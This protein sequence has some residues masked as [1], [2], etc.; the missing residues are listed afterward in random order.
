LV[1]SFYRQSY[2]SR[3]TGPFEIN[4][5]TDSTYTLS[6][7][8]E[9]WSRF[10]NVLYFETPVGVGFSYRDDRNYTD[11][12]DENTALRNLAAMQEFYE[13]FP[14]LKK[15]KLYLSGESYAGVYIPMLALNI[16]SAKEVNS[17]NGGELI[18]IAVGNGCTGNTGIC[19]NK[20]NGFA[21][22]IESYIQFS[23]VSPKLRREIEQECHV[24]LQRCAESNVEW[25]GPMSVKCQ[26][27]VYE[28]MM[29]VNWPFGISGA[30]NP[31]GIQDVCLFNQCPNPVGDDYYYDDDSNSTNMTYSHFTSYFDSLESDDVWDRVGGSLV[32]KLKHLTNVALA[33]PER[34]D[35]VETSLP[36]TFQTY[37]SYSPCMDSSQLS[38]FFNDPAVQQAI[39]VKPLGYC[40]ALCHGPAGWKYTKQDIVLPEQIYPLLIPYLKIFIY[41]GVTDAVVPYTDNFAWMQKMNFEVLDKNYWKPWFYTEQSRFT[42]QTAGY[43]TEYNI[44]KIS[45]CPSASFSFRTFLDAGHMVPTDAPQPAF[46]MFAS[47]VGA[48]LPIPDTFKLKQMKRR[49]TAAAARIKVIQKKQMIEKKLRCTSE[50]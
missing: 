14:E 33:K 28:V 21:Y 38:T 2:L 25:P 36:Y 10:A 37:K 11:N 1:F 23:I 39:H 19:S 32:K 31:Y 26:N 4:L 41:N 44:S 49:A 24:E 17:W 45:K 47:F 15:N 42:L 30:I 20:C 7:R 40:Y 50:N 27:L 46:E 43:L 6:I 18:G 22:A 29:T 48:N 35:I 8:P 34:L 3:D 16:L 13:K 5:G 9:R 12:N